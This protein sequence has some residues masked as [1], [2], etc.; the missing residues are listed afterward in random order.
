MNLNQLSRCAQLRNVLTERQI[1][2]LPETEA[3][4][5]ELYNLNKEAT[6]LNILK[7]QIAIT[8]NAFSGIDKQSY[9]EFLDFVSNY[10]RFQADKLFLPTETVQNMTDEQYMVYQQSKTIDAAEF[11]KTTVEQWKAIKASELQKQKDAAALQ[12][13]QITAE[14]RIRAAD[15]RAAASKE[16]KGFEMKATDSRNIGSQIASWYEGRYDPVSNQLIGLNKE[17]AKEAQAVMT[18]AERLYKDAHGT[19]TWAEAA[20]EAARR[21]GIKIP[22]PKE[23]Y[24][25]S[26]VFAEKVKKEYP[27]AVKEHDGEWY[28]YK[29]GKKWQVLEGPPLAKSH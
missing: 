5:T 22:T 28:V 24:R 21:V 25:R 9:P 2:R 20:T 12:R 27:D 14:S 11:L 26:D 13:T 8:M 15:I 3:R 1:E 19:T 7:A 29:D 18:I 16:G 10:V 4:E 17:A 6:E 23:V